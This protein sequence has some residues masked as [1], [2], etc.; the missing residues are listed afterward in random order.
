MMK[1][2]IV[3]VASLLFGGSV[4]SAV[5]LDLCVPVQGKITNNFIAAGNTLG[6]VAM[7]YGA[8]NSAAKFKCALVGVPQPA[9]PPAVHFIHSISCDDVIS[10]PAGDGSG[11]VPVHSSIVMETNGTMLPPQTPLELF[12]FQERSVPIVGSGARGRFH[13]VIGGQLLVEGIVYKS[14][15][16]GVPGSIDM[17]FTGEACYPDE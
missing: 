5:A 4:H 12:R 13:G 8:K 16:D 17:K 2:P 3:V 11:D 14:P 9:T 10:I 15:V 7:E 6:V 1:R